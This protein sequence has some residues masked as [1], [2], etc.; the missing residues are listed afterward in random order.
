M[1][2][3]PRISHRFLVEISGVEIFG[4]F[5][6]FLEISGEISGGDFWGDFW[7]IHQISRFWRPSV[8]DSWRFLGRPP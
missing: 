6:R 4:D 8:G 7:D 3:H 2:G 5:W 1:T